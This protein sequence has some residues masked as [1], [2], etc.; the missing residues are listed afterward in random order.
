VEL[1]LSSCGSQDPCQRCAS[2]CRSSSGQSSSRSD[3]D[4]PSSTRKSL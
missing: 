3:H 4:R 1:R 2:L